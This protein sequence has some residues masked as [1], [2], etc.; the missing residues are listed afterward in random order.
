VDEAGSYGILTIDKDQRFTVQPVAECSSSGIMVEKGAPVGLE[1]VETHSCSA[2]HQNLRPILK[3]RGNG[4]KLN[5][6]ECQ[7]DITAVDSVRVSNFF[8]AFSLSLYNLLQY[9]VLYLHVRAR[10]KNWKAQK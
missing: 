10:K 9:L 5:I 8:I 6:G 1:S 4:V 7:T 3:K 2:E